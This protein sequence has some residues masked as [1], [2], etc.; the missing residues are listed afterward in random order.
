[1]KKFTT[2]NQKATLIA[3][4]NWFPLIL[5]KSTKGITN[6]INKLPNIARTPINL[7]G[8]DIKIA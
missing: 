2:K 7:L 3:G 1:M 4:L 8:I 6:K 5:D